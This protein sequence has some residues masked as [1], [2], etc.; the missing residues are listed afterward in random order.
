MAADLK[1]MVRALFFP[2]AVTPEIMVGIAPYL[3]YSGTLGVPSICPTYSVT[4][5]DLF[6][7]FTGFFKNWRKWTLAPKLLGLEWHNLEWCNL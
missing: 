4:L 3:G 6:M 2:N 1:I 5:R 7:T